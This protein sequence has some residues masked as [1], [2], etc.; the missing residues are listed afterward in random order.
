MKKLLFALL[1]IFAF[2]LN[3]QEISI[4]PQP[5]EMYVQEGEFSFNGKVVVCYPEYADKAVEKV[6]DGFVDEFE[7][8]T[9][10][11]LKKSTPKNIFI[12]IRLRAVRSRIHI[13]CKNRTIVREHIAA[14][15]YKT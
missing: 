7:E 11:K 4:I 14:C 10:V 15:F 8:A 2:S 5:V 3:A 6:I 13:L 9:G 12:Q 1:C